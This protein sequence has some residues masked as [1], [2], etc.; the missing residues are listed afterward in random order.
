M[1]FF[2]PQNTRVYARESIPA[3]EEKFTPTDADKAEV[4]QFIDKWQPFLFLN[5]W[6]I[7]KEWS[8]REDSSEPMCAAEITAQPNYKIATITF[9]P[10]FFQHQ[11]SAQREAMVLHELCHCITETAKDLE[12][13]FVVKEKVVP[14]HMFKE[15]NERMTTHIANIILTMEHHFQEKISALKAPPP[16]E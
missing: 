10:R 9:Y 5:E 12:Y 7:D 4:D 14:W 11:N 15:A 8:E 13:T 2:T 6:K 1:K 3:M 16:E